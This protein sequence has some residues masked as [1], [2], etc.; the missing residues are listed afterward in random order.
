[1]SVRE[2]LTNALTSRVVIEQAKGVLAH[3]RGISMEE[4]FTLLRTY[5]RT[6][7]LL[8]SRVAQGLVEQTLVI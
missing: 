8:L 1:M 7:R 5:A 3:S 2:Q 4:A 6:N